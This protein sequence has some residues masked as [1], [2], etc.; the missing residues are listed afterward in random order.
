MA[1][2]IVLNIAAVKSSALFLAICEGDKLHVLKSW[3]RASYP[4]PAAIVMDKDVNTADMLA[5]CGLDTYTFK[6]G[7]DYANNALTDDKELPRIMAMVA[8]KPA[9]G[10][11]AATVAQAVQTPIVELDHDAADVPSTLSDAL[12]DL[13]KKAVNFR[14]FRKLCLAEG[15]PEKLTSPNAV[16]HWASNQIASQPTATVATPSE[17]VAAP[18]APQVDMAM[19]MAFQA[20]MQAQGK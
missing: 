17:A 1:K 15:M 18:Q 12:S 13:D 11:D 16:R 6:S 7:C 3:G 8:G 9:T 5:K 4:V 19:F 20:F 2:L 10:F 14:D